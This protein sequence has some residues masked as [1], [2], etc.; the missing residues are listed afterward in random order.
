MGK[1]GYNQDETFNIASGD[2]TQ[3]YEDNVRI[4]NCPTV[5]QFFLYVDYTK[6]SEDSL[7]VRMEE[8]FVDDDNPTTEQYFQETIVDNA[9]L[10]ELYTFKFTETGKY[11]IPFQVGESEDR[12]RVSA[13]GTGTPAFDGEVK[14]YF[15]IR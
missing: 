3:N 2:L 14:L 10:V 12:M 1:W 13:R 4:A 5:I 6:G 9:G 7:E 11:R 8:S 15:G